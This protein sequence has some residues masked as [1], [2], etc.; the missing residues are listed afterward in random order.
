MTD[1]YPIEQSTGFEG[2]GWEERLNFS[3]T[4]VFWTVPWVLPSAEILDV[5][6]GTWSEGALPSST[7]LLP[8]LSVCP[9]RGQ[10]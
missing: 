2:R 4:L 3:T 5:E 9:E 10:T 7:D 8:H 1:L 6:V